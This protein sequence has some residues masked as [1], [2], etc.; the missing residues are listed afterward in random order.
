MNIISVASL[1]IL[2][3]VAIV[4]SKA[5]S[6]R[7]ITGTWSLTVCVTASVTSCELIIKFP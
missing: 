6:T 1:R 7:G 3:V 5:H 2:L 4:L